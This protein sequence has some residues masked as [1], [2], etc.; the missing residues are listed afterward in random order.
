MRSQVSN[1]SSSEC[2]YEE[3]TG[4]LFCSYDKLIVDEHV[5]IFNDQEKRIERLPYTVSGA[6]APP[7]RKRLARKFK[8]LLQIPCVANRRSRL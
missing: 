4:S 6:L 7:V 5:F 8:F 3:I 2:S 1:P